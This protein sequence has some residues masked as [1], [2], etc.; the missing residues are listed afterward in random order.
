MLGVILL[1]NAV[2]IFV[3]ADGQVEGYVSSAICLLAGIANVIYA[4]RRRSDPLDS[5][6]DGSARE[7]ST[8]QHRS[9]RNDEL[10][11]INRMRSQISKPVMGTK[12]RDVGVTR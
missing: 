10:W 8:R 3:N 9:R 6:R 1:I 4:F 5:R 2:L 11:G 12:H 7:P